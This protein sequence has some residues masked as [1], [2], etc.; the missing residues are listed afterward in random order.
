MG[1]VQ[2]AVEPWVSLYRSDLLF[3]F[4]WKLLKT[5]MLKYFLQKLDTE[6]QVL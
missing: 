3:L 1:S 6:D 5:A 2:L 4:E